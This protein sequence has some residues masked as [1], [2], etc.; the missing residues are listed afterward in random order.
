MHASD[1][2]Y[3]WFCTFA[4]GFQLVELVKQAC[5][6]REIIFGRVYGAV[7]ISVQIEIDL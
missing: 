4:S 3:D 6:E 1:T 2:T 5:S 7:S